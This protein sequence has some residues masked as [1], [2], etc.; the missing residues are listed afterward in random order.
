[1]VTSESVAGLVE[2]ASV[3]EVT[4]EEPDGSEVGSVVSCESVDTDESVEPAAVSVS[5]ALVEYRL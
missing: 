2:P 5:E 4:S 3:D 1:M